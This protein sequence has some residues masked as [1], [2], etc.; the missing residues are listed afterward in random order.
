MATRRQA[1]GL[2]AGLL[3]WGGRSARAQPVCPDAAGLDRLGDPLAGALPEA[4]VRGGDGDAALLA[5]CD[6]LSPDGDALVALAL[7]HLRASL[8]AD[9]ATP[10][11]AGLRALVERAGRT[12]DLRYGRNDPL[13][14]IHRPYRVTAYCGPQT[15]TVTALAAWQPLDTP[16]LLAAWL[17]KLDALADATLGAARGL[18]ADRDAGCLPPM[19]TGRA[20]LAAL[21]GLLLAPT[22]DHPLLVRLPQGPARARAEASLTRRVQPAMALLRDTLAA[23]TRAGRAEPGLWAQKGGDALHA[24]N[25]ARAGDTNLAPEAAQSYAREEVARINGLLTKRLALRGYKTGTLAERIAALFAAHPGLVASDD[26]AGREG[27]V[28]AARTHLDAAHAL[29]GRLVPPALATTPPL[30]V[31]PLPALGPGQPGGSFYLPALAGAPARLWLDA[32]SVYALPIPGVAPIVDR[33]GLPGRHLLA[34]GAAGVARPRLV[35]AAAWPALEQGW[36][37][38]GDRLAAEAGLFARDPWGDV[39]RLADELLRA[40]R[41]VADVGIHQQRWT[42]AEAEQRMIEMT[43]APQA[44]ALDRITAMPGEA[45]APVLGLA[46]L[47]ELRETA[48]HAAGR[49]FDAKAF[50]EHVLQGGPRPMAQVSA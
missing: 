18:R 6:D 26:A 12:G 1:L 7:A 28:E 31:A 40:A 4:M 45:A 14:A 37:A 24:A 38:Y 30:E 2:A 39:A 44:A 25:I 8:P 13:A 16:D 48:R 9:C 17:A 5:R 36:A 41:L 33:L 50:H 46:R 3:L 29:L 43:G 49:K 23:L 22:A 10:E 11:E 42:R 32:R 34:A 15:E 47:L 19:L 20:A 27:L 35:A 21:D